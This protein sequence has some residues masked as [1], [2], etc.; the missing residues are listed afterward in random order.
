MQALSADQYDR[1][2][3]LAQAW[4]RTFLEAARREHGYNARL[5]VDALCFQPQEMPSGDRGL[6]GALITPVSLSLALVPEANDAL[7]PGE[8]ARLTLALPSGRYPFEAVSLAGGEWLWQC[9]LL[10]DLADLYSVQDGSRLAQRLI[11]QV[12]APAA[13]E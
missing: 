10:E 5:G 6:L 3:R 4:E 9:V 8:G 13:A 2:N 1:L 12:M 7:P 11:A